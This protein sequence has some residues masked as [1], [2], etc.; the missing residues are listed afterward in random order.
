[1]KVNRTTSL[2]LTLSSHLHTECCYLQ[3]VYMCHLSGPLSVAMQSASSGVHHRRQLCQL[4]ALT[5]T[6]RLP[7]PVHAGTQTKVLLCL[8]TWYVCLD[9]II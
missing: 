1:M 2:Y 9:F 5:S 7:L 4:Q 3:A 8:D 6:G